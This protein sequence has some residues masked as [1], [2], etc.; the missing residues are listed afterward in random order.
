MTISKYTTSL[1]MIGQMLR[2][3]AC[4]VVCGGGQY[5]GE[6]RRPTP[7]FVLA[8]TESIQKRYGGWQP[9]RQLRRP[10]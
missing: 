9:Q 5:G 8:Q 1:I 2:Q 7:S 4:E 3:K 10:G 6:P